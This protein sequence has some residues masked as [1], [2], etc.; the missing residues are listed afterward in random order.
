MLDPEVGLHAEL[1]AFLD[2]EGLALERFDAAR[3]GQIDDEVWAALDLERERGDD[4]A[5]LVRWVGIERFAGRKPEGG[6]PAVERFVVLVW[7]E[8]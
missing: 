3:R 4:A 5:A 7:E 6:F 8:G 2:G 1:G